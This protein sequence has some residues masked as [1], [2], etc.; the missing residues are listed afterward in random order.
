MTYEKGL[1]HYGY[2][3]PNDLTINIISRNV[4]LNSEKNCD[5]KPKWFQ[6]MSKKEVRL[7]NVRHNLRKRF[8]RQ[9]RLT[10]RYYEC[11]LE[12]AKFSFNEAS[13]TQRS[14]YIAWY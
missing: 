10:I 6:S 5:K 3:Q 8:K 11:S 4:L 13:S 7:Q 14:F 9:Y 2:F 1:S 12:L